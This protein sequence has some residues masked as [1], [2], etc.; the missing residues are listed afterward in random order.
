MSQIQNI[1]NAVG[2]I[3]VSTTSK[4]PITFDLTNARDSVRTTPARV[5]F[6]MQTGDNEGRDMSF[7]TLGTLV[8]IEWT[9]ADLMLYSPVKAGTTLQSALPELVTYVGN[10]IATIK[11]QHKLGLSHVTVTS[12]DYE[13]NQFIFPENSKNEYYGV[14]MMLKIKEIIP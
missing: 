7:V 8:T 3:E 1:I 14:L 12:V 2:A 13:W 9:L 11:T 6:P 5:V 4:T 10:Y